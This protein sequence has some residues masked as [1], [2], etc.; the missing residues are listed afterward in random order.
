[1]PRK[2]RIL[3]A[4]S[5]YHIVIRGLDRQIMFENAKDYLKY[6]EILDLYKSECKF[7]LYA[8]CLM[9][10]H[11]HLLLKTGAFSLETIFRK[12]NTHYACWFNM[13]YQ[14]T[15]HLQQERY[16]SEPVE[17][18][19]YFLNVIR[20]IHRNPANAGLEAKPGASYPWSSIYE[21]MNDDYKLIN[22]NE[23]FSIHE[24]ENILDYQAE[25]CN[26]E[27]LDIDKAPRRLPD[28][29]AKEIICSI[30]GIENTI[31]FQETELKKRNAFIKEFHKQ[32]ISVR[33]INRLTGISKGVIQR[34]LNM[35]SQY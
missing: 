12:I 14:R 23:V 25:G 11:V 28:D 13:K 15:G 4:S 32:G 20:Y 34:A 18:A 10:N 24:K 21:Y 22:S 33:Q 19:N 5:I 31:S 1:M 2:P 27:C 17:D 29:V 7:E 6:L 35:P 3:A 8:Y 30:A 9:S 26:N 16:Y